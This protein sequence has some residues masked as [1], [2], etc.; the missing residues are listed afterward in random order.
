MR[1]A[2]VTL[3]WLAIGAILIAAVFALMRTPLVA[4]PIA[5]R[6]EAAAIALP[7]ARR[8]ATENQLQIAFAAGGVG[9]LW[10]TTGGALVSLKP[11]GPTLAIDPGEGFVAALDGVA[12]WDDVVMV[13]L[14]SADL[15]HAGG[16]SGLR[17]ASWLSGRKT[18]LPVLGPVGAQ[19]LAVGID[20]AAQ[21]DDAALM[22]DFGADGLDFSVATLAARDLELADG[23]PRRVFDEGGLRVTALA[24]ATAAS[25]PVFAYRIEA[26]ERC[27]LW[28]GDA[29]RTE[30]LARALRGC[31]LLAVEAH[32]PE[33]LARVHAAA[34]AAGERRSARAIGAA[35]RGL[36]LTQAGQIAGAAGT[37][38]VVLTGLQP[39]PPNDIAARAVEAAT[40]RAG[41]SQALALRRPLRA[42][43][44]LANGEISVRQIR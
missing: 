18:P 2:R 28:A 21:S 9:A 8:A 11:N 38:L 42:T 44:D 16:L 40:R 35:K 26:G 30:A 37:A 27:V 36:T 10:G 7:R 32:D 1:F 31:L 22:V 23:A 19:G 15:A 3:A 33:R 6:S 14:S 5:R 12:H 17:R 34:D 24:I 20:L 43:I 41:A 29:E 4:E 39:A 13:L 25:G